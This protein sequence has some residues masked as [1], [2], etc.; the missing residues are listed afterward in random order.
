MR[1]LSIPLKGYEHLAALF[2]TGVGVPPTST[3]KVIRDF[4]G[5]QAMSWDVAS[6]TKIRPECTPILR[7]DFKI[8]SFRTPKHPEF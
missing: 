4:V 3:H 8:R 6:G 7:S 2:I 5:T 1:H